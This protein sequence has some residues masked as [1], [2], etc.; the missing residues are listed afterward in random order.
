M[1][2]DKTK[3]SHIDTSHCVRSNARK[4]LEMLKDRVALITGASRGMGAATARLL[5]AHGATVAVNYLNNREAGERVV[6]E[7]KQNGGRALLLQGD[8]TVQ[9]EAER[10]VR[11]AQQELGPIDILV[12]NANI[13]FVFNPF[14][15]CSWEEFQHKVNSELKAAYFCAQEAAAGMKERKRGSII[16]F[17]SGAAKRSR[18]GALAH[19]V[20]KAA[21][22]A[23]VRGL[24]VELGPSNIR[25]NAI[26]PGFTRTDATADFP[27]IFVS[28]SPAVRRWAAWQSQAISPM[29]SWPWS[30][31]TWG[32]SPEYACRSTEAYTLCRPAYR[33]GAASRLSR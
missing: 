1:T 7:I 28:R 18:E 33:Q 10:I 8:V 20:A 29:L 4:G 12:L 17:S 3:F 21:I 11:Q 14:L 5:A 27:N 16:A 6:N 13:P 22:E 15:S 30:A 25:V 2:S 26:A 23:F 19:G 32:S 24:A 9:S 31:T